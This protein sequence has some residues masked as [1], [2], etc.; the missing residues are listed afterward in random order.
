LGVEVPAKCEAGIFG[1]SLRCIVDRVTLLKQL[2]DDAGIVKHDDYVYEEKAQGAAGALVEIVTLFRAIQDEM[3]DRDDPDWLDSFAENISKRQKTTSRFHEAMRSVAA[4][5]VDRGALVEVIRYFQSH[6]AY[7][8]LNIHDGT[9]PVS[10]E[11]ENLVFRLVYTND[12][13]DS[14]RRIDRMKLVPDELHAVY[15]NFLADSGDD[16]S[17]RY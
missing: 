5:N 14:H 1:K 3:L 13:D 8:F 6:I 10:Y 2:L 7:L 15:E 11:D 9:R 4:S 16:F 12:A 17:S